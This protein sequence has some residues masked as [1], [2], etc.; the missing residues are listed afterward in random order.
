MT[1]SNILKGKLHE[2]FNI[3]LEKW[4]F[5]TFKP[6][7]MYKDADKQIHT[8]QSVYFT[9]Y[10]KVCILFVLKMNKYELNFEFT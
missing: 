3:T 2:H 4:V 10:F 5:Y 7:G 1:L 9:K 8:A 6:I